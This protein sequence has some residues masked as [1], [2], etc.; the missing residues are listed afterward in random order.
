MTGAAILDEAVI[1]QDDVRTWAVI[2]GIVGYLSMGYRL[3][4][5]GIWRTLN[6]N[7]RMVH[8]SAL[9]WGKRLETIGPRPRRDRDNENVVPFY[10]W[11]N[12]HVEDNVEDI[13]AACET[14]QD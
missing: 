2:I 10:T 3:E 6:Y 5:Y 9:W 12:S 11:T 14:L 8:Y 4:K 13:K 1:T 7:N